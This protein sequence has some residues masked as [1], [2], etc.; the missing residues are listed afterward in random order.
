MTKAPTLNLEVDIPYSDS[1]NC[2][3]FDT[4]LLLVNYT[5]DKYGYNNSVRVDRIIP[6]LRTMLKNAGLVSND[7]RV[8]FAYA[9]SEARSIRSKFNLTDIDRVTLLDGL[10][11]RIENDEVKLIADSTKYTMEFIETL[12]RPMLAFCKRIVRYTKHKPVQKTANI[13]LIVPNIGGLTTTSQ[14]LNLKEGVVDNYMSET[15]AFYETCKKS[16]EENAKGMIL[17]YGPP[18]TGKTTLIRQLAFDSDRSFLFI[19][20]SMIDSLASPKLIPLLLQNQNCVLVIEDAETALR[21]RDK[22]FSQASASTLLQLSDGILSDVLGVTVIATFNTSLDNIDP[23]FLRAGRCLAKHEFPLL[24]GEKLQS[25]AA[26]KQLQ[27]ATDKA[28]SIAQIMNP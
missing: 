7:L 14:Q 21:E 5:L 23:A 18:G 13:H 27:I 11:I 15:V 25:I 17:M 4:G 1:N 19:P 8:K 26:K 22:A 2:V 12:H 10:D 24:S 6:E 20:A 9:S 3:Y 16:L 28:M